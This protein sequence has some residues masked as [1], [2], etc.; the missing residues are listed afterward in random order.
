MLAQRE[1]AGRRSTPAKASV[2]KRP[3]SVTEVR[4]QPAGRARRM[5]FN[6]QRALEM[7]AGPD[8]GLT[9]G[10]CRAECRCGRPRP[11]CTRSGTVWRHDTGARRCPGR[12][13]RSRGAVADFGNAARRNRCR[14]EVLIWLRGLDAALRSTCRI[15]SNSIR[16]GGRL[17]ADRFAGG[18]IGLRTVGRSLGRARSSENHGPFTGDR[19][20]ESGF[21]QRRVLCEPLFNAR[22]TGLD[23][24]QAVQEKRRCWARSEHGIARPRTHA[25]RSAEFLTYVENW[26]GV[27]RRADC[28]AKT[29]C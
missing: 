15:P 29:G 5:S 4:A 17:S 7:P 1:P 23:K 24:Q 9:D 18:G 6:D 21:L 27:P 10:N 3:R 25:L 26:P 22:Q 19:G 16:T 14:A 20:F 13:G 12:T 8:R 11:V 2:T 28:W